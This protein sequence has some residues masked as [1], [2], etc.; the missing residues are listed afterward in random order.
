MKKILDLFV[1]LLIIIGLP[2]TFLLQMVYVEGDSG[3]TNIEVNVF[4]SLC[5]CMVVLALLKRFLNKNDLS[6]KFVFYYNLLITV[7]WIIALVDTFSYNRNSTVDQ[8]R[9]IG[10]TSSILCLLLFLKINRIN[11]LKNSPR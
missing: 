8:L 2:L 9:Y 4:I 1:I 11:K 7:I 10:F 3:P 5:I 6:M